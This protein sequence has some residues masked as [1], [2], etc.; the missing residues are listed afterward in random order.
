MV[1][2]A[3][4]AE[5]EIFMDQPDKMVLIIPLLEE[6]EVLVEMAL[7]AVAVDMAVMAEMEVMAEAEQM[8]E[9]GETWQQKTCCILGAM[10]MIVMEDLGEM[11]VVAE[12]VAVVDTQVMAVMVAMVET[13]GIR[14]MVGVQF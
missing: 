12:A 2:M 7:V 5:V 6:M 10:I 4:M 11:A 14:V 13:A 1:E 3:V 8:A 9:M